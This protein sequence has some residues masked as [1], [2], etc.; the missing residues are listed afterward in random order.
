MYKECITK[1][2]KLALWWIFCFV[3]DFVFTVKKDQRSHKSNESYGKRVGIESKVLTEISGSNIWAW[4][5]FF[6][7]GYAILKDFSYLFCAKF[8]IQK[9]HRWRHDN[10]PIREWQ[11]FDASPRISICQSFFSC[12]N[13]YYDSIPFRQNKSTSRLTQSLH[14]LFAHF[15]SLTFSLLAFKNFWE[16]DLWQSCS[17]LH[18]TDTYLTKAA[19]SKHLNK[20]EIWQSKLL[21]PSSHSRWCLQVIRCYW[22]WF[23][24][25]FL[26]SIIFYVSSIILN[27]GL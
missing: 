20:T 1:Y 3:T 14:D 21:L 5:Y 23:K 24:V 25:V 2:Y 19:F 26:S 12:M 17:W 7:V 6:Q 15:S 8:T 11:I 18:Q 4:L 9:S 16:V 27:W 13:L 22:K 10:W